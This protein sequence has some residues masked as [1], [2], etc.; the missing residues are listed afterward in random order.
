VPS[1]GVLL[2]ALLSGLAAGAVIGLVALGFTLVAGTV[3]VLHLAHGDLV[4][5]AVLTGVIGVLGRTPVA[6]VLDPGRSAAFV[7]LALAAG[8]VLSVA[9]ALLAVRPALAD[10][11]T[12]READPLGVVAGG[13]AA[14][15]LLRELLGLL[16]PAQA[17]AVPDPLRLQS[18]VGPLALPGGQQLPAEVLPVLVLGLAAG[19]LAERLLVRSRTGR[20]L[21]AVADDPD[22]AALC[23]ISARA[24]VLLAF[25][26]AGLLAGL[27]GLL[28]AS[29][30]AVQ[31]DDGV[32]LGLAGAASALL[33]GLGSLRGALLGGLALGVLQSL[34]VV[35]LGGQWSDLVPLAVL[36]VLLA[37]RPQGAARVAA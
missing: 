32:V 29:G 14:G 19:L 15:L 20:A 7:V 4:V 18:V 25:G 13:V 16:L 12:G 10:P 3:R 21:R 8:A 28:D 36:V 34:V 5:A 2:Q 1:G 31:V 30:R 6:V 24:A 37:A 9:V 33:G 26:V 11:A 23:G 27:A 35:A 17:S 22:A